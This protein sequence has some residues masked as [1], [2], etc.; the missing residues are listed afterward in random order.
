MPRFNLGLRTTIVLNLTLIALITVILIGLVV[1]TATE[2]VMTEQ[3]MKN[4]E[5]MI[6]SIG[7]SLESSLTIASAIEHGEPHPS[8]IQNTVE[9]YQR[10]EEIQE[11]TVV[12]RDFTIIASFTPNEI[13]KKMSDVSLSQS[14]LLGKK[15]TSSL[16]G[17]GIVTV[18]SPLYQKQNIIGG[19]KVK[20]SL[21]DIE[22][23]LSRS[24]TI[25]ILYI[26]FSAVLIICFG[27]FLL[28][29]YL[30]KPITRLIQFTDGISEGEFHSASVIDEKNEIGKLSY[31][32]NR[33]SV[34]LSDDKKRIEDYISSLKEANQRLKEAQAEVLRSE[35]LA[36]L[37]RLSAGI[38]HEIGNPLGVIRGYTG[39]LLKG[40]ENQEE[41]QDYFRRIEVEIDRINR[42]INELLDYS[43]ISPTESFPVDVNQVIRE[44]LSLTS[45]QKLPQD[46]KLTL[47]L[48]DQIPPTLANTHQLVQVLINLILNARDAMPGGGEITIATHDAGD[49]ITVEIGDTGA[50]IREEDLA[51][52]FDPFYTTKGPGQ[53]TGLGL[54]ISLGIIESLGGK[55]KVES[56]PGKG[57]TF[58]LL[59]PA[60]KGD[61][62]GT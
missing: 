9:K 59:L 26:L 61:R 18:F 6:D 60:L 5:I 42:I 23:S 1:F 19:F 15:V 16:S 10:N 7:R 14:I 17:R 48:A 49:T 62:N 31:S 13:G 55:I 47:R 41:M 2:K 40:G 4:E 30:V 20:I 46:I 50:G 54:A 12:D 45:L 34:R 32:L 52:I 37:G 43:R 56:S 58:T 21:S 57:T 53:G 3:R 29:R 27:T 11:L 35:K 22:Q 25:V 51:K 36:S 39:M 38:A 28:S 8:L 24:R 44:A 33:M